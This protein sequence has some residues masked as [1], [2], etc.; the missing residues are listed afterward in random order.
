LNFSGLYWSIQIFWRFD[1]FKHDFGR[2]LDTSRYM[3]TVFGH[4]MIKFYCKLFTRILCFL[5]LL[6][7]I[8]LFFRLLKTKVPESSINEI[9]NLHSLYV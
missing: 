9:S 1:G 4:R 8:T 3:D 2:F 6:F 5:G 7:Q